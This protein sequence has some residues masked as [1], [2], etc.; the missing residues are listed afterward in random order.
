MREA[1]GVVPGG[2]DWSGIMCRSWHSNKLLNNATCS[3]TF[4]QF[5]PCWPHT[6]IRGMSQILKLNDNV[7][8]K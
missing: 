1:R 6:H 5:M 8:N 3:Q 2:A 7:L 4:L